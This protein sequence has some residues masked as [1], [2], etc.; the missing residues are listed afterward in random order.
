MSTSLFKYFVH[1]FQSHFGMLRALQTTDISF[2]G[3]HNVIWCS[4]M[5]NADDRKV[6]MH[7]VL[8]ILISKVQ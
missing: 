3:I 8:V 4:V 7:W 6:Y 5:E 1:F 2:A